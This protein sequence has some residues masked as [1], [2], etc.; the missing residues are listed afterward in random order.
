MAKNFKRPSTFGAMD[1]LVVTNESKPADSIPA[2]APV[3]AP[4]APVTTPESAAPAPAHTTKIT[5]KERRRH[6][7]QML[8]TESSVKELDSY[9]A[10]IGTTRTDIVQQLIDAFLKENTE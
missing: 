3:I 4:A 1:D 7:V 2:I 10:S 8:L 6:R 9:A 5:V